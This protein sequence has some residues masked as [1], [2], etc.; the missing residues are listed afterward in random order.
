MSKL[1]K[2]M[3][4]RGAW[5][6]AGVV[7]ITVAVLLSSVLPIAGL[8]EPIENQLA[9]IRIEDNVTA[10]S[11][12][13]LAFQKATPLTAFTRFINE[14][15]SLR[16]NESVVFN[17]RKIKK[18]IGMVKTTLIS[19]GG[20]ETPVLYQLVKERNGWKIESILITPQGDDMPST[21]VATTAPTEP[22]APKAV[23]AATN[24]DGSFTYQD[25]DQH[26]TLT[27]PPEWQVNKS[28]NAKI[29]FNGKPD[30]NL[31]QS[32]L[33]IQQL[34]TP[35]TAVSVQEA[36]D[37]SEASLKELSGSF[38]VVEDG[39]LPPRS[40]K[41]EK[42]HGKYAVYSYTLNNQPMKQ[43]QIIY[44]ISPKRAQYV[45][46]FVAPEAQ[47]ETILPTAKSMIASFTIS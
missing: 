27:Y 6:I 46:D 10:Y 1:K 18:G 30:S 5:V 22:E 34:S 24:T 38:K 32:A 21:Q 40:N 3:M 17:E 31:G 20:V 14:F 7:V 47:F 45:I 41:N 26:F 39:L 33:I 36:A 44:F 4:W 29:V 16:N 23:L 37:K 35:D 42:F 28:D 12:T 25:P 13:S 43:L 19:R 8:R 9:A 11:Y 15:S 2:I